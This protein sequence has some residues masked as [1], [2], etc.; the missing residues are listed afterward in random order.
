MKARIGELGVLATLLG[1]YH[2]LDVLRQQITGLSSVSVDSNTTHQLL[3]MIEQRQEEIRSRSHHY[4]R[5]LFADKPKHLFQR[6]RR[7]WNA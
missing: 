2:D 6:I 5:K 1:D 3:C 7:Y 4:G